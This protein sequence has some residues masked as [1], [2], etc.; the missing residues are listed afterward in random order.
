M[1]YLV[2][3]DG[4]S[5]GNPGPASIGAVCFTGA[6]CELAEIESGH[7]NIVFTI[8]EKIGKKT[9]NEAEYTSVMK[10][11]EKLKEKGIDEAIIYMD[12]ELV[13]RQING[14]YKVKSKTLY[15]YYEKVKLLSSGK[16][17]QFLHVKREKNT[18]AD[19]LANMAFKNG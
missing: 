7:P 9:N 11:I 2:F 18:I 4:A 13:I 15:P 6:P 17:F 12:S 1:S 3:T 10:A 14:Q 5:K 19:Y 16:K 8:S